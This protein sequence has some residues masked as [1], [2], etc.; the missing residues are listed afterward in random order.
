MEGWVSRYGDWLN[1]YHLDQGATQSD[2][3]YDEVT[4]QGRVY[5]GM[6]RIPALHVTHVRGA[7]TWNDKGFYT[8]DNLSAIISF[9][10][11]E[12]CGMTMADIDTNNYEFD[13]I[14]YD[15]KVFR[16]TEIAIRGKIVT[17]PTIVTIT[18]TQLKPDE[19]VEDTIFSKYVEDWQ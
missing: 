1:Y 14:V 15:E 4:D 8:T 16:V 11:Y 10:Q 18:A 17:R 9:R 3:V 5:H 12:Q 2:D 13:R 7:N 19:L 6:R